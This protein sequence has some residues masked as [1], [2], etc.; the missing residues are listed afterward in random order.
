L[1]REYA[2]MIPEGYI[3]ASRIF[4]ALRFEGKFEMNRA[5]HDPEDA[6]V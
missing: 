1:L 2:D 4:V 6:R 5:I 3:F